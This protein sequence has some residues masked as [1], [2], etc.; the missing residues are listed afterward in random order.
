MNNASKKGGDPPT[1]AVVRSSPGA[2][3]W[4]LHFS[5]QSTREEN[6]PEAFISNIGE[7]DTGHWIKVSA[8]RDG[9][10]VVT[11]SRQNFTK[12][13]APSSPPGSGGH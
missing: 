1:M 8:R 10:F 13:Y 11:N 7:A 12:T 4:Q 3:L 2:D 9:S 6:A 5:L